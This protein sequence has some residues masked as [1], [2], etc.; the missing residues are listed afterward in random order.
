MTSQSIFD[1][2]RKADNLNLYYDV[3]KNLDCT[4]YINA[5]VSFQF[6]QEML[7]ISHKKAIK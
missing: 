1:T 4:P 5:D 2:V 7:N 6:Y 3:F